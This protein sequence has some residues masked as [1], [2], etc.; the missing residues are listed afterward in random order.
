MKRRN[1]LRCAA[2]M[3]AAVTAAGCM[4]SCAGKDNSSSG[5]EGEK[6]EDVHY[7]N[8]EDI[9]TGWTWGNV[10]IVGGGYIPGIIYNPTEEG[11]AYLRTDMGGAYRLNKET[12]RWECITDCIG[13]DDWNLNGIESIATDPVEPNRVYITCGTYMSQGSGAILSSSDYGENWVKTDLPFG[14][15]GNELGR[16]A[17]ERLAIDPNDNSIIY[18]GSR[19][20]G[21]YRS[22]DYGATWQPVE[23]FP[24]KGKMTAEGASM[25]LTFVA[26]DKSSSEKGEATKTIFVGAALGSEDNIFRS[27]DGGETWSVIKDSNPNTTERSIR[28][29]YE[30]KVSNGFLYVTYADK[31]FPNDASMGDVCK[32]NISTGEVI[33]ITP[34]E[35]AFCGLDVQGDT[36]VIS[37]VCCW[38][39]QDNILV[40]YDGGETWT[41]FWDLSSQKNNYTM[42]VSN[43]PWLEWHGQLKLGWWT[44]ALALNPFNTEELMYGTGATVYGTSNLSAVKTGDMKIDVRAMGVEE[45][46]ISDIVSPSDPTGPELYS[47]MGDVYGFRHDDVNTPP[48]QHFGDFASTDLAAADDAAQYVVRA[49]EQGDMPVTYSTDSGDTWQYVETLPEGES[50]KGGQVAMAC[51][52]SSFIWMP[53]VIGSQGY[54][55]S[56]FGKTWTLCDG[57]PGGAQFIADGVDPMRYYAV[58]DGSFY[59]SEDGGKTFEYIT[60]MLMT[61]C[62]MV[63]SSE[64]A[65]E[66]W[67]A[68][69]G[70]VFKMDMSKN[71][72]PV[73]VSADITEAY[74]IGLGK[75]AEGSDSMAV[76]VIGAAGEQGWGVYMSDD[77]G[78]TWK[79]INDDTERW[80]NVNNKIVGDPKVYGRCYIST[81]G[82]GIIMGNINS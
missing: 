4:A 53:G 3:L 62:E 20:E 73:R 11:L 64:K 51:D 41:G 76:Y 80:G 60:A 38:V 39:P 9:D 67:L 45:C 28:Y 34:T 56:D 74:A 77:G 8:G 12:K 43:A 13:A 19:T 22:K 27:D 79:K 10:Q 48:Q 16:G 66:V 52:G 50:G 69:G 68:A 32:I 15:G 58:K 78:A 33:N 59:R 2:V 37:T 26:F 46:A 30:G 24:T 82:R 70:A 75:G 55:T 31:A 57:L 36:V 72:A 49:T 40:S 7:Y 54:V 71:D 21:L 14:V 25:G 29:P 61:K 44:S 18:F 17:G 6:K 35:H 65:N 23:S 5:G 81:N 42:D 63:A 47:T 1:L